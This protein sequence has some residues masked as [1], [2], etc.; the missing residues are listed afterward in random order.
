MV[1]LLELLI[2]VLIIFFICS[3]L[4]F[5]NLI[6]IRI[7]HHLMGSHTVLDNL[8]DFQEFYLMIQKL[9]HRQLIC[10][11]KHRRKGSAPL[12][13]LIGQPKGIKRIHIRFLKIQVSQLQKSTRSPGRYFRSG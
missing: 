3:R 8:C 10:R 2:F 13:R 6:H 4:G 12:S 9:A 11:I 1:I 7:F 5:Q